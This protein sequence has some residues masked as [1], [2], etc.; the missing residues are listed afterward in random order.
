MLFK[1]ISYRELSI[2]LSNTTCFLY[3]SMFQSMLSPRQNVW[4]QSPRNIMRFTKSHGC[5]GSLNGVRCSGVDNVMKPALKM[6]WRL[7][8]S[9]GIPYWSKRVTK[10]G[11]LN[12]VFVAKL[13]WRRII[14]LFLRC[15]DFEGV[16]S[17]VISCFSDTG[18]HRQPWP[19]LIHGWCARRIHVHMAMQQTRIG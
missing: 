13:L 2:N 12:C 17:P 5:R 1:H 14:W 15:N 16:E 18:W 10:F 6:V 9:M 8:V 4:S 19:I 7:R 3:I 11:F